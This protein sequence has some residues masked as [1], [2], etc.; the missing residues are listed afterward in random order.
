VFAVMAHQ[1]HERRCA[2]AEFSVWEAHLTP[3]LY[4]MQQC[5]DLISDFRTTG[6]EIAESIRLFS[7]VLS[8]RHM[9]ARRASR[10]L[11]SVQGRLYVISPVRRDIT[12]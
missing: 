1:H 12:P 4:G 6:L 2:A 11:K 3:E 5:Y 9:V 10:G 7:E 8:S